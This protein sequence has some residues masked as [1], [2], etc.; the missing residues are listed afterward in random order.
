M[1]NTKSLFLFLLAIINIFALFFGSPNPF[2]H[3]PLLILAYPASLFLIA[4]L[5][6]D[7]KSAFILSW[8]SST[9]GASLSM[10]WLAIPVHE[11][12]YFPWILAFPI[13]VC[14]GIYIALY[15]GIFVYLVRKVE[16]LSETGKVCFTF[17]AWFFLEWLRSW[18]LSGF[19]W[20]SLSAS[21]ASF[22]VLIQGVSLIGMHGLSA[23][24]A[25]IACALVSRSKRIQV[26]G[27][28][29]LSLIV[30][31][32]FFRIS[33]DIQSEHKENYLIVQGNLHQEIKWDPNFHK[34][35]VE[36]YL[37]LTLKGIEEA[38]KQNKTID[39][40]VFPETSMPFFL[41]NSPLYQAIFSN[42]AKEHN[43]TLLVGGVRYE[44]K[45][46][47]DEIFNSI[48]LINSENKD[49]NIYEEGSTYIASKEHLVPFGEYLPSFLDY[50]IL[51][52]L[53]QG[54]GGF[55]PKEG[56]YI[57]KHNEH[58]LGT[59]ICYEAIFSDLAYKRVKQGAEILINV[60]N[61][62]WYGFSS[63]AK[64]HLDI[65]LLRAVEQNRYMIRSTNTGISAFINPYG[66][67]LSQ[68]E[69]YK[70]VSIAETLGYK[71][72]NTFYYHITPYFAF[73]INLLFFIFF[74]IIL[75]KTHSKRK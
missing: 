20:L 70:G 54:F 56:Q 68:T 17:F 48:F 19:T 13:P 71:K 41:Q 15:A 60:S 34:E 66:Q 75:V 38:K 39:I 26:A 31:F 57:L 21:L 37:A 74:S 73:L 40:A 29:F 61:D 58:L 2:I 35:T 30:A 25:C 67:I 5:S 12:A 43:I 7:T 9:L 4:R 8:L 64:Q 44:R 28:I 72:E 11:Y 62:A 59:L 27:F 55:T 10:Y 47:K 16:V 53:L 49:K 36:K 23:V 24:F 50:P 63:A 3:L 52:S 22:P 14:M 1:N 6:K 33:Q 45:K 42:F 46:E 32:G 18:F 51:E 65:S 69:L